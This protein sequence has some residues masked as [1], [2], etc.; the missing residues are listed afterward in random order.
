MTAMTVE[1]TPARLR[2]SALVAG[3]LRGG[4]RRASGTVVVHVAKGDPDVFRFTAVASRRVGSAVHRN[5][6]KRLIREATR[7]HAWRRGFDAVVVARPSIVGADL[8]TVR[9]DVRRAGDALGVLA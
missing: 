4:A 8:A 9:A 2:S 3:V 7:S 6:A 1:P 5:R